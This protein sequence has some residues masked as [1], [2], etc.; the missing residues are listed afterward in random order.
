MPKMDAILPE[1]VRRLKEFAVDNLE[2]VILYGSAARGDYHEVHSDLNVLC[3]LRSLSVA[4]LARIAPAVTWW[5]TEKKEPAPLFF[6]SEELQRSA[7]VFSIELLDIQKT[8]RVLYGPDIVSGITVP[9]NLHRLQVEHD[10]RIII[11][12]LRQ[13]FL[14]ASK[15]LE[16]L[17]TILA[18]SISSV[19]TLLRHSLIAWGEEPPAAPHEL[20][21]RIAA[22][23][24]AD[25]SAFDRAWHARTTPLPADETSGVYGAYLTALDKVISTLDRH[26]PKH[27][28]RR[29]G[30]K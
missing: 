23:C 11:L 20:F 17:S 5:C 22:L 15:K 26:A 25:A 12:K 6:S 9:M 30:G 16:D 27:E 2:S 14:H 13:R 1:L 24:G 3:T 29:R 28:W 19:Q 7:D 4:E 10:L 18:E 8:H 21:A